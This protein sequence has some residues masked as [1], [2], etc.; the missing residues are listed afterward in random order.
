M[1]KCDGESVF[2]QFAIPVGH[3]G[4][5]LSNAPWVATDCDGLI[6][7]RNSGAEDEVAAVMEPCRSGQRVPV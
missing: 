5:D 4:G 1:A 2:L 6:S 7:R 3:R